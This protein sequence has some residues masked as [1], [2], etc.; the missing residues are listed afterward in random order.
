MIKRTITLLLIVGFVYATIGCA[1][2]ENSGSDTSAQTQPRFQTFESLESITDVTEMEIQAIEAIKAEYDYFSYAMTLTSEAYYDEDGNIAGFSVLFCE[3]LSELFGIRFV[4]EIFTSNEMHAKLEAQEVDFAGSV[5]PTPERMRRFHM[6]DTITER[7][8]VLY[9]LR[10]QELAPPTADS[11]VRYAF[12]A[13]TPFEEMIARVT[14]HGTYEVINVLNY[15]EAYNALKSGEADAFIGPHVADI[16]FLEYGDVVMTEY[17]PIVFNPIAMATANPQLAPIISVVTKALRD[18]GTTHVSELY[19]QGATEYRKYKFR[20]SLTDEEAAYIQNAAP[21][22]LAVQYFNYPIVFYDQ[23]EEKWDGITFDILEQIENI[24]GLTFEVVNDTNAEMGELIAMLSDG[25]AKIFSD[26]IFTPEREPH[27]IWAQNQ[28]AAGQYALI[29][30]ASFP[31]INVY[32]IPHARIALVHDTAHAEMFKE[33]FPNAKHIDFVNVDEAVLAMENDEI[34]MLMADRNKLLYYSNYYEFSGYKANYLFNY[35]N[36][37]AFAFNKEETVLRSIVDKAFD[38]IDTYRITD[39]WMSKT[40]NYRV[41]LMAAQ[42]RQ[43]LL[44]IAVGVFLVVTILLLIIFVKSNNDKKRLSVL[45]AKAEESSRAKSE[46]LSRMSHEIRSPMNAILGTAEIQ[47]Q[48]EDHPAETE[49]AF[50]NIYSSGNL[51]LNIINDLLDLS[52]AEANKLTLSIAK[53]DVPSLVNDVMQLNLLRYD[54]KQV[55]LEL[56][57]DENTPLEMMGDE[58]RIKQVLNNIVSNAFKYTERGEVKLSISS[59]PVTD[60]GEENKSE[61]KMVLILTVSDTGQGMTPDQIEKLYEPYSRFNLEANRTI[62]GVG[63]GMN[64]TK[65]LIDLMRGEISVVSQVNH[66]TEITVRIPQERVGSAVCGRDVGEKLQ[67]GHYKNI[68][69]AMKMKILRKDMSHGSVLIVDDMSSNLYVAK[70]L[71]TPYGLKIDT[72]KSGFEA[73]QRVKDGNVYDIIFMDYMMPEMDG[74]EATR[75]IRELGYAEPIVALTANA[76]SGQREIFLSKGFDGFI[77]KPIDVRELNEYLIDY[78]WEKKRGTTES[79]S[80]VA[81]TV[82]EGTLAEVELCFIEDAH[83]TLDTLKNIF[84]KNPTLESDEDIELYT[85]TVHGIK[86]SLAN[87]GRIRLSA[88]ALS[89]E[90]AGRKREIDWIKTETPVFVEE[91]KSELN[92]LL[93]NAR[94]AHTSKA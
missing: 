8:V 89:L 62:V 77:T 66:G 13:S 51:L 79:D 48:K 76:I 68:S 92:E 15:S 85:V 4:P 81:H 75:L 9:H 5:M 37:S 10:G 2:T 53:Y 71:M 86:S 29:S 19:N 49:E 16:S 93:P 42:Q 11:P 72:V 70:G 54:S 56:D 84:A 90:Q 17:N 45:R 87:T 7:Q 35:F 18:G 47:L 61:N 34:D 74:I 58:L 64:I 22:P 65:H 41:D 20:Y 69:K 40:Y 59:E 31:N 28:Y 26:L 23:H 36:Y 14:P 21:I 38:V 3:W 1:L 63:L 24:T 60:D 32:D 83:L 94:K 52:K 43:T 78:I 33:W 57:V 67:Q 6:T 27:F 73:V 88:F 82:A 12:L 25:R 55:E 91:L 46:F 50:T 80:P 39:Q 44:L 30:K